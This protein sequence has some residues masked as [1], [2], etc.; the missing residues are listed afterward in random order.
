MFEVS[1]ALPST[2]SFAEPELS[3]ARLMVPLDES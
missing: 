3:A 1:S 2:I